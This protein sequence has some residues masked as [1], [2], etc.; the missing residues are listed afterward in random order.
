MGMDDRG[1]PRGQLA[2]AVALVT[3]GSRGIGA[4]IARH[5]GRAG[6]DVAITYNTSAEQAAKVVAEVSA[7]GVRSVAVHAPATERGAVDAAVLAAAADLGGL[8]ILVNN[9][10]IARY[11]PVAETSDEDIDDIIDVNIRAVFTGTRAALGV[12]RDGGRVITIGSNLAD[13]VTSPGLALYSMSK[14]ALVGF[15]KGLA[16]DLGPRRITA[17]LVQ[18]GSTD[19]D[20]NPASSPDAAEQLATS[21]VGHYGTADDIAATV[22]HL[23]GP[24][25][26]HI[27]GTVLTIDGGQ[28]T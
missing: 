28:N 24:G 15:T 18:P 10:G 1:Q 17:N 22:V 5:L 12:L 19:T 21:V 27:T 6:A 2:G 20:M 7:L 9:A 25:G 13:R 16:H 4:A 26:A 14:S 11:G 3:G 23:A 8:D